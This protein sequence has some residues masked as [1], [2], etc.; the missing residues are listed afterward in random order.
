MRYLLAVLL[1]SLS[2]TSMAYKEYPIS[3]DL[4]EPTDEDWNIVPIV[5]RIHS[6][7][8]S[9]I[10]GRLDYARRNKLLKGI[11]YTYEQ[12]VL[13]KYENGQAVV[14]PM[15]VEISRMLIEVPFEK[16]VENFKTADWGINLSQILGGEVLVYERESNELKRPVRQ[17]ERMVLTPFSCIDGDTAFNMDMTKVEVIKYEKLRHTVYWRVMF[18]DNKSTE[19]DVGSVE[20]R[21]YESGKSILVTF[22]SAHRLNLP[23]EIPMPHFLVRS[24]LK[25]FFL[26]HIENYKKMM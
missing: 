16:F 14:K 2:L 18:S 12:E 1:L 17:L 10:R 7:L 4:W 26:K 13:E 6:N 8:S 5:E 3:L 20:F 24:Y 22:H 25:F 9:V 23:G 21:S 15:S 19:S 11:S